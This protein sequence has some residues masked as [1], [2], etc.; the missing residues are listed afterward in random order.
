MWEYI[1]KNFPRKDN[2]EKSEIHKTNSLS[3]VNDH[4]ETKIQKEASQTPKELK[5]KDN[6]NKKNK[7]IL[8]C[9]VCHVPMEIQLFPLTE[10]EIDVCP[11][12]GGIFLDKGELK[13]IT[14]Y[15]LE[16]SKLR[17]DKILVYT[18]Y[19]KV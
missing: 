16:I 14:G 4:Q 1:I 19:G 10:I 8:L 12:C 15:E 7:R 17:T 6:I 3:Y 18:P 5:Y 13:E 11:N 2:I 9:P